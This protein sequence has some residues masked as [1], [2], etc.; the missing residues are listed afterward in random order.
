[1]CDEVHSEQMPEAVVA[2]QFI[3]ELDVEM[4]RF[5]S[6]TILVDAYKYKM[7]A[8]EVAQGVKVLAANLATQ[9]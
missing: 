6:L 9:V 7:R 3:K 5:I 1:M 8:S 2:L 4:R